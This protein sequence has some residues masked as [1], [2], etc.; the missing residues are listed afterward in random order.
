MV[1]LCPVEAWYP[2]AMY[3]GDLTFAR[4]AIMEMLTAKAIGVGANGIVNMRIHADP[5]GGMQA[6]GDAVSVVPML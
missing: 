3:M 6:I 4:L 1:F 5:A 2:P